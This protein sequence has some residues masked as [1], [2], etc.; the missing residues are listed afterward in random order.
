MKNK[1]L[2]KPREKILWVFVILWMISNPLFSQNDCD[3]CNKINNPELTYIVFPSYSG[4]TSLSPWWNPLPPFQPFPTFNY[5]PPWTISNSHPTTDTHL[6]NSYP[7]ALELRTWKFYNPN[8]ITEWT[9]GMTQNIC[10]IQA[11]KP[12]IFSIFGAN[13]TNID[14]QSLWNAYHILLDS[15]TLEIRLCDNLQPSPLPMIGN[16]MPIVS[17]GLDITIFIII[18]QTVTVAQEATQLLFL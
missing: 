4:I 10:K 7:S 9:S 6:I 11:G 14:S 1:K 16:N 12:Y 18:L 8:G 5:F 17:G 2:N 15:S 3:N 13:W